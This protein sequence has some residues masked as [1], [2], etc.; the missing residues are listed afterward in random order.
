MYIMQRHMSK[1]ILSMYNKSMF[2]STFKYTK[3][4]ENIKI[5]KENNIANIGI[6]RYALQNIGEIVYVDSPN[7]NTAFKSKEPFTVLES[8]KAANDIYMPV[9]GVIIEINNEYAESVI[10]TDPLHTGWI[11]KIKYDKKDLENIELMNE[12][13]YESYIKNLEL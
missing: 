10:N 12:E 1:Y 11:V 8:T 13:E 4:H 9:N 5:N 2:I 3:K 6:S 7:I